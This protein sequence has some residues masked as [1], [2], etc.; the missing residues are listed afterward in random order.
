LDRC[1]VNEDSIEWL[2]VVPSRCAAG[3]LDAEADANR[4]TLIDEDPTHV[5]VTV[6]PA[7]IA[8]QIWGFDHNSSRG[9]G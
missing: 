3:R 1:V 7:P 6:G 2:I 8:V 5:D 4:S 9:R